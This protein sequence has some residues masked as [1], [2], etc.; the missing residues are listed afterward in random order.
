MGAG[1][2]GYLIYPKLVINSISICDHSTL[3]RPFYI[4]FIMPTNLQ[5]NFLNI[6]IIPKLF[7]KHLLNFYSHPLKT[8]TGS[9]CL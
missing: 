4:N 8:V 9:H 2:G 5:H 6:D 1:A 7:V 3:K